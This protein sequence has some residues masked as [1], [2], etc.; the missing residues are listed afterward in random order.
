MTRFPRVQEFVSSG[1][2]VTG[3]RA[4]AGTRD[5]TSGA[6]IGHAYLQWAVSEAAVRF[7]RNNP[8]GQQD[9]ARV[10]NHQGKGKALTI[11]AHHLARAVYDRR[12]RD[13]VLD[14]QK[15]LHG[16][17]SGAGE[18]NA[19]LDAYGLSLVAVH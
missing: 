9:L 18:P 7:L 10:E 19:S 2:R 11:L 13:T 5:G 12:K 8:V 17:G 3:A 6:K 15:C 4:S 1:R 16:S 14:R